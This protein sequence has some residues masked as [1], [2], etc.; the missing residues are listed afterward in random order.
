MRSPIEQRARF[1]AALGAVSVLLVAACGTAGDDAEQRAATTPTTPTTSATSATSTP[2]TTATTG[3]ESGIRGAETH[4]RTDEDAV[5]GDGGVPSLGDPLIATGVVTAVEGNLSGIDLFSIRL[6]D[7]SDLTFIP[8]E[9][10]LFDGGPFPH[11]RDHLANGMPIVVEYRELA[12]DTLSALGAA[13][14]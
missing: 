6:T 14:A 11:I 1:L 10:A 3:G 7:G 5:D 4:D 12:D 9:G 2:V 13:D 8:I